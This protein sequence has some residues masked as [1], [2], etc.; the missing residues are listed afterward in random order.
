MAYYTSLSHYLELYDKT[1]RSFAYRAGNQEEHAQWAKGLRARLAEISGYDKGAFCAPNP[2]Y[3]RTEDVGGFACEVW[4]I[5]TEPGIAMPFDLIWP[6]RPRENLPVLILSH[7]H[8]GGRREN[9]L[10]QVPYIR[11]CL[12]MGFVVAC[13]DMRGSGERR[14][15]PEQGDEED[16][17]RSSSHRELLQIMIGFGQS[18][19]GGAAWDLS[20]LADYL[21]SL[22]ETGDYLVASGMS[23]G[24][25][26]TL[27]FAA[28]DERVRAAVISGYF[29]GMKDALVAMPQNCACNYVPHLYETADMGD[30]GALIA[31]RP[32]FVESGR[33]DPLAGARGLDNVC[34]QLEIT[35]RAYA[36]FGAEDRLVHSVHEGGHRWDGT[37][38]P[39]FLEKALSARGK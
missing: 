26:Q 34:E 16:K 10:S 28:L 39:E 14:E 36:L 3:I 22:K 5:D 31:P 8:G 7:G 32:M 6:D 9:L 35:R 25:E 4:L 38:A 11:A 27:W 19:I 23:G 37:G 15:F 20:R 13:P 17:R 21:L 12:D 18:V 33:H 1:E 29:Y 30:I 2:R 24:G